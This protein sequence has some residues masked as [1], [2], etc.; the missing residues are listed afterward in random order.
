M[1]CIPSINDR[2]PVTKTFTTLHRTILH[3]ISL[4][5]WTLHFLSFKLHPTTNHSNNN[6]NNNN[7]VICVIL[8][9][10]AVE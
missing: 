4:N 1:I 6:N 3:S 10:D 8:S 7:S 9:S 2:H 5:L